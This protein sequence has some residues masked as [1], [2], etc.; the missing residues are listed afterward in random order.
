MANDEAWVT[1]TI[2]ESLD[3]VDVLVAA[4]DSYFYYEPNPAETPD[5]RFPFATLVTS[6]Q[7]D[8]FSNLQRPSVFRLN[9]GVSKETFR[10]QF[11]ERAPDATAD[12]LATGE[13]D[14]AAL[15]TI[16]P[17]PVYGN[18]YWVCVLNP[19]EATF[20]QVQSLLAEAHAMAVKRYASRQ[21]AGES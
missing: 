12:E 20:V 5:R 4:G 15:D 7:H 1:R 13:Y 16:M 2:T 3:G 14:F 9:V 19:S 18:M 10:A 21:A 6:D 17:H 11:G 8:S